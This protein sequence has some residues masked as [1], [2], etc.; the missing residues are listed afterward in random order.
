MAA[1]FLAS[2]LVFSL[3]F[4]GALPNLFF[5][6]LCWLL[7]SFDRDVNHDFTHFIVRRESQRFGQTKMKLCKI[8][9]KLSRVK[10]LSIN[11]SGGCS[12]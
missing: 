9:R 8:I 1:L 3:A 7:V 10:E 12:P 6:G 11:W 2:W 4:A 5:A